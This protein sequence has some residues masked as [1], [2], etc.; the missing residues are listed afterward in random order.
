[1][2]P[3]AAPQPQI[4]AHSTSSA[5]GLAWES[6]NCRFRRNFRGHLVQPRSRTWLPFSASQLASVHTG[7]LWIPLPAEPSRV[8]KLSNHETVCLVIRSCVLKSRIGSI[9]SG[10]SQS[11]HFQTVG[12]FHPLHTTF[13]FKI[14]SRLLEAAGLF[15]IWPVLVSESGIRSSLSKLNRLGLPE[16][17]TLYVSSTWILASPSD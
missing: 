1:M 2:L 4:P 6:Q 9:R 15:L 5:T 7:R 10:M 13:P 16:E 12:V 17:M 11:P 14:K 8:H 3:R